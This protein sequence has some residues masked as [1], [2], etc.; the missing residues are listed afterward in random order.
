MDDFYPPDSDQVKLIV[1]KT[2]MGNAFKIKDLGN[3]QYF[4]DI[5][6]ACSHF[7][8]SLCQHKYDLEL[9][10]ETTILTAKSFVTPIFKTSKLSM[11]SS[12]NL[13][14]PKCYRYLIRR[15]IYLTTTRPGL[16][17]SVQQPSQYTPLPTNTHMHAATCVLHYIKQPISQVLFF[18]RSFKFK[19]KALNDF[20]LASCNATR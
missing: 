18:H 17:L 13:I 7:G 20:D 2:H 6:V 16:T 4:L 15:L 1:I 14:D 12:Y 9:F 8:I 19:F 11:N 10:R 5:E 3:L